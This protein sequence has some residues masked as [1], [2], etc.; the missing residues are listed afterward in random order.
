[1][2]DQYEIDDAVTRLRPDVKTKGA[3]AS[4]CCQLSD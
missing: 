3:R 1:M 4:E 2:S